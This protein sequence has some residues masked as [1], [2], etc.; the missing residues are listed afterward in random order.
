MRKPD[1]GIFRDVTQEAGLTDIQPT[2]NAIWL[3]FDRDGYIDLYTGNL[4]CTPRDSTV[5][6]KRYRNNGDGTFADVTQ[7][8]GLDIKLADNPDLDCGGGTLR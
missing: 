2:D 3:D 8:T 4:G 6:N 7:E 5:R 1:R